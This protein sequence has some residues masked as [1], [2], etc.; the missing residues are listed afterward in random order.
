[1]GTSA[2]PDIYALCLGH[3]TPE[4]N[5]RHI[6]QCASVV[7]Q[8]TYM[9]YA[10]VT[11]KIFLNLLL[12]ALPIYTKMHNHCDYAILILMFPWCSFIQ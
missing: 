9:L 12:T 11:P 7:L 6:K 3:T 10:T 1:M 2:L 8:L 4:G 5:Y